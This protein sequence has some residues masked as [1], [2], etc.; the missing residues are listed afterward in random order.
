MHT[1]RIEASISVSTAGSRRERNASDYDSIGA[2][3][4]GPKYTGLVKVVG[5]DVFRLDADRD[6]WAANGTNSTSAHA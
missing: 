4:N 2:R 1:R 6:G 5:P 3:G